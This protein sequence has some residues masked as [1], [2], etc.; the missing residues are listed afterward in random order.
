MNELAS[1]IIVTFNSKS[2]LESCIGSILKQDYP[3]EIIVVDNDSTDGSCQLLRD[4]FPMVKLIENPDNVGYGVGNNIGVN[5]ANGK[6]IVILNPD[7][8]VENGWLRELI[9]SLIKGDRIIT[10]PKILTFKGVDINTCGTINHFTGLTFTRGLRESPSLYSKEEQVS[11][12]SGCCFAIKKNNYLCLSGFDRNFF[13]YNEDA[14]LSWRANLSGFTI[15]FIPTS[16]IRHDY[17]L[18][19]S[20]EK[21]Y[22]L[23]R[24]RYLILRKYLS[25]K[26][27]LFLCPSLF[28]TEILTLIYATI[29]GKEYIYY[30]ILAMIHGNISKIERY[31]GNLQQLLMSLCDRIPEDQLSL[32]NNDIFIR[33]IANKIYKFNFMLLR[34]VAIKQ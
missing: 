13:M 19:M 33:K 5:Y 17:A 12:F 27:V 10:T 18:K 22:H 29:N 15:L 14:D 26:C 28:I 7:T 24:G 31:D 1:I 9:K 16:I 25:T 21:I 3:H 30:K 23:E 34:K 6:Y 8:I 4:K 2:Y 32:T 20:P 11:G